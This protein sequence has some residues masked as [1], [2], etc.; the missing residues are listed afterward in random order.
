MSRLVLLFC[1]CFIGIIC[2]TTLKIIFVE[3]YGAFHNWITNINILCFLVDLYGKCNKNN[4]F[5]KN[6]Q[7]IVNG[8]NGIL[9][10]VQS[11]VAMEF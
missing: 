7:L 9:G 4:K 3:R 8:P 11:H 2:D 6:F 5:L 1:V 10:S